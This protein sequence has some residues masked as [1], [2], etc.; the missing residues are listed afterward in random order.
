MKEYFLTPIQVDRPPHH[1]QVRPIRCFTC[2]KF[3]TCLLRGDYL[4]TVFLIQNILG[5]PQED[6]EM[7]CYNT[8]YSGLYDYKGFDFDHPEEIFP[9][10]ITT[11]EDK[12][13]LYYDSKW[14]S[15]NIAQFIYLI[16]GYLVQFD[17]IYDTSLQE[18]N[19]ING[20]EIYYHIP[21]ELSPESKALIETNLKN[22]REEKEESS[23]DVDIIN[24]TFFS[25]QL[26]CDFYEQQKGLTEEDGMRRVFKEFP[27]YAPDGK[28]LYYHMATFHIEPNKVPYY[29]PN[30]GKVAF[31][32][33][34]YPV[35]VP[36]PCGRPPHRRE[37]ANEQ[38]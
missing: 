9:S 6:R 11:S 1:T 25:A 20:H 4:K 27:C 26:N 35:F 7:G 17:A 31:A 18:F 21:Y 5:D 19:I 36:R 2:S 38:E 37:D 30:A 14:R 29:N 32:P 16:E 8:H 33:F 13:G 15:L 10:E 12:T 34:P 28:D 24:T 3:P 23:K 22:W